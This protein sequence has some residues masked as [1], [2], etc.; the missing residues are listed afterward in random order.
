MIAAVKYLRERFP[1]RPVVVVGSSLGSAAAIFAARS[2]DHEVNGFFLESPYR[3]LDTAVWHRVSAVPP[4]FSWLAY[5]G[6]RLWGRILL[7]E[8]AAVISPIDHVAEIPSDVRVTFA[9]ARGDPWCKLGEVEDLYNKIESHARLVVFDGS[10][11]GA[12]SRTDPQRYDAAL[13]ELLSRADATA[14]RAT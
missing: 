5:E 7:P 10:R 6:M 11:H 13:L 4:P 3:D 8:P 2:L 12:C 9:A 14:S 1:G